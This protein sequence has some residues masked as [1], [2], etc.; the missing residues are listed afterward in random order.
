MLAINN[1]VKNGT[2]FLGNAA[3]NVSLCKLMDEHIRQ[4]RCKHVRH[5]QVHFK[6]I[7]LHDILFFLGETG[8]YQK[9][10]I[11]TD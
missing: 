3:R 7:K 4:N 5:P 10:W 11:E 6:N 9:S 2:F 1:A 8:L